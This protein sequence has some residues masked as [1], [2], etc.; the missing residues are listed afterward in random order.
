M[1]VEISDG[2]CVSYDCAGNGMAVFIRVC[3]KCRCFVRPD[4]N[5]FVGEESGLRPGPNA[6]CKRCG[7][8]EMDFQGFM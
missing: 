1:A 7:R 5:I 2:P 4:D 6:T 3:P 8:V